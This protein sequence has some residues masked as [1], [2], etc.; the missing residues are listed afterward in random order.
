MLMNTGIGA[1][2]I[3]KLKANNIHTIVVSLHRSF[4]HRYAWLTSEQS[5]CACP[6][7]RLLKIKG[8]SDIKVEKIKEIGKK[9]SVSAQLV[10][11]GEWWRD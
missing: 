11:R 1:A 5:L 10:N 4:H 7:K 6:S 3:A 2:D 9:L 8:F